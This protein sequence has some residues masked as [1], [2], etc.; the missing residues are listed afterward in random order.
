MFPR[1]A[2]ALLALA[3]L[4]IAACGS[5]GSS[6]SAPNPNAQ[7]KSPPGD[8]PDNQAYVPYRLSGGH[9]TLKVPEGWARSTTGTDAVRFTDKLNSIAI[10]SLPATGPMTL[11]AARQAA[12][13]L[14]SAKVSTIQRP[15]GKAALVT[16]LQPSKPDPVTGRSTTDAVQ[17]YVFFHNG[18]RA[19][20]TLSGPKTADNVDPW[21]LVSSSV[22]WRP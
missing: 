17:R 19:V 3:A 14:T 22:R 20:L 16:Y 15:A 4:G 1:S 10:Q 13:G 2:A 9:L 8:I 21:K 11:A 7:E 6:S 18:R 12:A 5:G